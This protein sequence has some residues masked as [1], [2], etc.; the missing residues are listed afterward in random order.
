MAKKEKA[1]KSE[2]R[3]KKEKKERREESVDAGHDGARPDP[4]EIAAAAAPVD[5]TG[6]LDRAV[7][8]SIA[9]SQ[10][11]RHAHWNVKGPQFIALH[12]L[13]GKA[14]DEVSDM[15]DA[16]AER[17]VTLGGTVHGTLSGVAEVSRLDQD[18]E[19]DDSSGLA[20]CRT[21]EKSLFTFSAQLIEALHASDETDPVTADL[22]NETSG[23]I[24]KL[25]WLIGAHVRK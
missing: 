18:F 24:D 15:T 4:E 7:A 12:E 22:F 23:E 2:K 3:S 5:V 8:E 17:A 11:L 20:L 10:Q 6:L 16:L 9:L 25:A 14:Y 21:L 1:E 19:A 13:F